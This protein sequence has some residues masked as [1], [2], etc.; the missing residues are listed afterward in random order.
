MQATWKHLDTL[1]RPRFKALGL[2][3]L[4]NILVFQI[5]FPLVSP[6]M[7][8][9]MLF[10]F[11]VFGWERFQHP[12]DY[13]PE[14]L[15]HVLSYYALFLLVDLLTA[16]ISFILEPKEDWTFILALLPQRFFYRQLMYYVAIKSVFTA[17][18]GPVV[19]WG[20]LERKATVP[21][22]A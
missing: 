9:M 7:D 12:L 20:K 13:S 1:L 17:I 8:L 5:L 6:L 16:S 14:N 19:G 22:N 18:K 21:S 10:S 2:I 4:P 15:Y 11:F 3:A